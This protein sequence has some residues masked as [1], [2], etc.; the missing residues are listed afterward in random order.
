MIVDLAIAHQYSLIVQSPIRYPTLVY[1]AICFLGSFALGK[2]LIQDLLFVYT[3]Q[4]LT[5][6]VDNKM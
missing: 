2:H 1:L 4:C 5:G 3:L 6:K